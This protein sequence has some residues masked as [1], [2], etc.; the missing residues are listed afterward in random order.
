VIS[1]ATVQRHVLDVLAQQIMMGGLASS[2]SMKLCPLGLESLHQTLQALGHTLVGWE[3]IFEVLGSI[4]Q[5]ALSDPASQSAPSSPGRG[6]PSP[7]GYL[8]ERCCSALIKITFQCKTF[9]CDD[10]A[11]LL[12]E[13]LRLCIST[14]GQFGCQADKNIVL[15]VA[16]SLF[17][18][19]LDAI[20]TKRQEVDHEQAYSTLWMHLL[21]EILRLCADARPEV[22]MGA[23]QTLFRTA[24]VW[25]HGPLSLDTWDEGVWKVPLLGT[26]SSHVRQNT[27]TPSSSPD[28]ASH[29]DDRYSIVGL[30]IIIFMGRVKVVARQ[31]I[32]AI[33]SDFLMSKTIHLPSFGTV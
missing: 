21:L 14:L 24:V 3:S 31:S 11:A 17:W 6:C 8:Q 15:M 23:I 10:L 33:V 16:E 27:L 32:A 30:V 7:L 25:F 12:P 20:Q 26:L 5:P 19:V 4:C 28:T 29:T 13:H 9:M 22:R 18:G 2:A 1:K